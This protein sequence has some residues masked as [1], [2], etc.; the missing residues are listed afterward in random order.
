LLF[1]PGLVDPSAFSGLATIEV[2]RGED[3]GAG[4]LALGNRR[5]IANVRFRET[6]PLLRK[7]KFAVDA[8]DLW[9][10]GKIG[11]TPASLALAIK[12]G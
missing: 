3:F 5:V 7:A 8:I 1:A 6:I 4:V 9:E 10:F 2:P 11:V 12:R